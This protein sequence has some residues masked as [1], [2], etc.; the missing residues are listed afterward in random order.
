MK[1][2]ISTLRNVIKEV[3]ETVAGQDDAAE[4]DAALAAYANDWKNFTRE[5]PEV[6]PVDA[7]EAAADGFFYDNP[8]WQK[9]SLGT[10]MSR[11]DMAQEVV[12][13][14]YNAMMSGPV[15]EDVDKESEY[16]RTGADPGPYPT[17]ENFW[18]SRRDGNGSY[19]AKRRWGPNPPPGAKYEESFD[20][21]H[22]KPGPVVIN[23]RFW[24]D[25]I[26]VMDDDE[27]EQKQIINMKPGESWHTGGGFHGHGYTVTRVSLPLVGPSG[28]TDLIF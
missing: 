3:L 26:E 9:W 7:A 10:G 5:T 27:A 11:E 15:T 28:P 21:G 16:G 4:F 12:D 17:P 19:D 24:Y 18:D 25:N 14:V 1:M 6:D 20:D 8:G 22:L 23:N 2:K 13:A